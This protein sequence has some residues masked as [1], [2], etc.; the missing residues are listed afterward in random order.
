[1]KNRFNFDDI[2]SRLKKA[3]NIKNDCE[4]AEKLNMKAGTFN[5]RKK[6]NS[7]PYEEVLILAELEKLDFNWVLTGKDDSWKTKQA[8][9]ADAVDI[10]RLTLAIETVEE[11]LE[12]THRTM[13]ADK[14]AQ[15]VMA[16]Y[17]LFEDEDTPT[18]KQ[19]TLKLV[20]SIA[21]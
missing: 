8:V 4:L 6:A 20:Q 13:V 16:I 12:R 11:G 1:M 15:L 7:L 21:A 10:E 18:I 5:A 19:S 14:K 9:H 3:L 17:D 2:I